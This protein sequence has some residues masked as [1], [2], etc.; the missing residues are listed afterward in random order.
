MR[1]IRT[2]PSIAAPNEREHRHRADG[3]AVCHRIV[4]GDDAEPLSALETAGGLVRGRF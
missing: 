4:I 3:Q 2:W 1:G